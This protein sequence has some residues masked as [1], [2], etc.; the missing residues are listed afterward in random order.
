MTAA[1][2]IDPKIV[3]IAAELP[4]PEYSTEDLL[5]A[6]RDHLSDSLVAML[7]NLGVDKRHSVLANYPE[8]LFQD[9]E[10]KL[11]VATA[12]LAVLAARKCLA[13]ADVSPESIG[14]VLGVS[15]SPG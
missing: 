11:D 7:S 8:V 5:A 10:P 6:G 4:S 1:T 15:S 12:D 3:A 13:K 9:A 2:E 14:L